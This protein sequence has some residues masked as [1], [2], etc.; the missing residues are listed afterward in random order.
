M[1]IGLVA[2]A[3]RARVFPQLLPRPAAAEEEWPLLRFEPE[4]VSEQAG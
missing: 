1:I 2:A 4:L 3:S